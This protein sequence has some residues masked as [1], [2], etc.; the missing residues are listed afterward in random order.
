[1]SKVHGA[2]KVGHVKSKLATFV[3]IVIGFVSLGLAPAYALDE[4]VIDVVE[5]TWNGAATPIGGVNV[6]AEVIDKEVNADWVKF[7]T[8][9]GDTENRTISFKT[10]K[11]LQ[12]PITLTTKMPCYGQA[13]SIFM[14]S[15]VPEA[16]KRLGISDY[17][18]RYLLVVSPKAGC[19]WS[20]RAQMGDPDSK[21]GIL[22]LHDSTSSFV[23]SHELGHTFGLGHSNF[24]R[25]DNGANDGPWGSNCK[26]VE[27]GGTIDVMGNVDTT[28][29]L[30][31]YHQWRMGLMKDSQVKQVWQTE[32]VN[33]A[34]SNFAN[35][36]KAIFVRD[37]KSAYWIEYRLKLEGVVYKPGLAIY[38]LDPPPI[39]SVVSP[40]PEDAGAP[41]YSKYL[42]SDFWMLNLDTYKY[43]TSS[44]MGGSMTGLSATTY[45]GDV[46]ISAVPSE[47]GAV[48][49]IKK[50]ADVTPPPVPAVLPVEQWISPN[51]VIL[52][53]GQEDADTAI[54]GYESRIND[55]IAPMKVV[56]EDGWIPT[57]LSPFVAPKTVYLR[58]LPEGS[59]TFAMRSIDMVGN[60]SDWSATQK[61]VIDRGHPVVTNDFALTGVNSKE[62]SVAWKGAIDPG[63]GICQANIVDEDGLIIQSSNAKNAPVFKVPS[64]TIITGIAQVFD[65]LGNGQLA[66]LTIATTY[67]PADKSSRTGKW[68]SAA[69][70]G[71]GAL[72][73]VGKCTASISTRGKVDLVLA[74]GAASVSIGNKVIATIAD[75]KNKSLTSSTTIDVGA[76]K[77]VIRITG[78]NFTLVGLAAVS[79]TLGPQEEID[80]RP[81][82]TDPSLNDSK[83]AV[84]GKQGFRGEDFSQEWSVLPM[85]NGT[86]LLDPSL[87]LCSGKFESEKD[88]AERRQVL[89]NK[90]GSTF[91]FLSTEVV[92]YT[93]A[94]AASAAQKELVKVLTQCQADKGYKDQT[95]TLVPYDFKK[96]PTIPAGVVSEGNRVFVHAVIGSGENARS[97]LGFY[98]FNGDIF[99]GLYVLNEDGFSEAQVA[100]WLKVAATMG[101]RLQG[102]AA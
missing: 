30:S 2:S 19:V 90:V 86:T 68:S 60:K 101:Q 17:K 91:T 75:N 99:S 7:T 64:G 36:I 78:S 37:G 50:K 3:A 8:M 46:S 63:S 45:S 76:T 97:L 65:C 74:G 69:N 85:V 79:T 84:L 40:N 18:E 94:A 21:N 58:D 88:R 38:R 22:I 29:P 61:V 56:D 98:Q 12:A 25:C 53:S 44:N 54:A 31:T 89:A 11:V 32:T 51:M 26:G 72:K 16:Y 15:I 49:T 100:K 59:F 4:R 41:E 62:L 9:F 80:R 6:L 20:G 71:A 81:V 27:Y 34:P 23:I 93:S 92:R 82:I 43:T 70:A 35:G 57:F 5:V 42:S 47:T 67:I 66:D 77:K 28:S 10:G 52:K 1:M 73:C 33:L 39:S 95:G 14:N 102:K 24:L 96:L 83:Q 48:V 55:V 87:D 13:S